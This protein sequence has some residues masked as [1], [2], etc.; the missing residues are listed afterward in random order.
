ME[1]QLFDV[2]A[3]SF[4]QIYGQI[5]SNTNSAGG[6]RARFFKFERETRN[7]IKN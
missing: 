5:E 3:V 4:A 1:N 2:T 7:S 6:L